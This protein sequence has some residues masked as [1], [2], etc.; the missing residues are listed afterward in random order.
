MNSKVC[1]CCKTEK[2]LEAFYVVGPKTKRK[3][4]SWCKECCRAKDRAYYKTVAPEERRKRYRAKYAKNKARYQS[5][6]RKGAKKYKA[7]YR[8]WASNRYKTDVKHR[9]T[10]QMRSRLQAALKGTAKAAST[11]KLLGCSAADLKTYLESLWLPGMSW[12]NHGTYR[13]GGEMTWHI[14]HIKPCVSFDLTD[15][16]QQR[17]CFHYTNLQPLWAVDNLVKKAKTWAS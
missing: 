4:H 11:M 9:L 13:V 17:K 10:I 2:P 6:N 5:Y 12:E 1:T 14:D 3:H 7:W 16:E 8:E 15:P